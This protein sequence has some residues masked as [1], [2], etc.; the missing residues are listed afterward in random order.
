MRLR[1]DQAGSS[2]EEGAVR[3]AKVPTRYRDVPKCADWCRRLWEPDLSPLQAFRLLLG[4]QPDAPDC[5]GKEGV[6][7]SC[8]PEGFSAIALLRRGIGRAARSSSAAR[9]AYSPRRDV[10]HSRRHSRRVRQH[11]ADR[12]QI[13]TATFEQWRL[14]V[15][16]GGGPQA[17]RP[18]GDG[19]LEPLQ[20]S[21]GRGSPPSSTRAIY[22]PISRCRSAVR[23]HSAS[24]SEFPRS[25]PAADADPISA[26]LQDFWLMGGRGL[27]PGT[28]CL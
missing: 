14:R 20:T 4:Q 9:A 2:P 3:R 19:T 27:E 18:P 10:R 23:F 25:V 12:H 24:I 13:R 16:T 1:C 26:R 22:R 21:P 5:D 8:P 15:E 17:R 6:G 28:S 7:G 11:P